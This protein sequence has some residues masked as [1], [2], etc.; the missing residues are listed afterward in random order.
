MMHPRSTIQLLPDSYF[1]SIF[2]PLRGLSVGLVDGYGNVGDR[3]IYRATRQLLDRFHIRWRKHYVMPTLLCRFFACPSHT[4]SR[5]DV[6]LLFGGGSMGSMYRREVALRRRALKSGIPSIVL[7]Q[8]FMAPE[9]GPFQNVFIREE[10]SRRFCPRGTLVPDLALAFR[11]DRTVSPDGDCGVF[12]R[13]DIEARF[14]RVPSLGDP[15]RLADTVDKYLE[16]AGKFGH[17]VTDRLH[18]AIAGLLNGRRVTLLPNTYHKNRSMW[19]CW[20]KSLGCEWADTPAPF[21]PAKSSS[22][23]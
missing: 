21:L 3:L 10:D 17:V 12:L 11:Y 5:P 8:S 13:R 2:E 18:F 9:D 7:P 16:L 1:A 19:E 23:P 22:S 14:A 6:L 20:L 15:A 4:K